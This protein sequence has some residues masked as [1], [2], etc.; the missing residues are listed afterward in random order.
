M[1]DRE[2]HKTN[3][4]FSERALLKYG[5]AGSVKAGFTLGM[6]KQMGLW[7][8]SYMWEVKGCCWELYATANVRQSVFNP[9]CSLNNTS[10]FLAFINPPTN[11]AAL[12]KHVL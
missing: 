9:S 11:A 3:S 12:R 6:E 2:L 10:L 8:M 7:A 1:I 5:L 4:V